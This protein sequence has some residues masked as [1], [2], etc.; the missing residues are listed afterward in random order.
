M[1][2][3]YNLNEARPGQEPKLIPNFNPDTSYVFNPKTDKW[4]LSSEINLLAETPPVRLHTF[5][6][7]ENRLG[8]TL[9]IEPPTIGYDNTYEQCINDLL[10]KIRI[11][12]EAGIIIAVDFP[13]QL[14]NQDSP[15]KEKEQSIKEWGER[16]VEFLVSKGLP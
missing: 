1:P 16:I 7:S 9:A 14:T 13:R 10:E 8:A 11:N 2:A 5:Y 4:Q 15:D 6:D 12:P 3:E